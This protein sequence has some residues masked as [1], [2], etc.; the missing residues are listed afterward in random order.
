MYCTIGLIKRTDSTVDLV[1]QIVLVQ[2]ATFENN[3]SWNFCKLA[4]ENDRSMTMCVANVIQKCKCY[5]TEKN[6]FII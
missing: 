2:T 4:I 3:H 6:N 1:F 5:S